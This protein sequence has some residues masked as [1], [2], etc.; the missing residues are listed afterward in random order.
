MLYDFQGNCDY[1]LAK[2]RVSGN[3]IVSIVA[4]NVP[5]GRAAS[6]AKAVI[7]KAGKSIAAEISTLA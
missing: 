2:G 7:I 6:C 5:C 3:A 4:Q 1:V